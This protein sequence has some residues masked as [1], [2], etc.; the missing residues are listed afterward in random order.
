VLKQVLLHPHDV[1]RRDDHGNSAMPLDPE[2]RAL[3]PVC[4]EFV[5]Q[6]QMPSGNLANALHFA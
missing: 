5:T 1:L 4:L 6:W 3:E 2:R